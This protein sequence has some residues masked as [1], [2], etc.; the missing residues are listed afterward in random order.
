MGL[1]A[2]KGTP[3][4]TIA[5]LHAA[6]SRSVNHPKVTKALAEMAFTT[7][8]GSTAEFAAQLRQDIAK[9]APVVQRT[10]FKAEG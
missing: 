10:G 6:A 7:N 2:P 8:H 5:R 9:W 3:S 1:L 4:D